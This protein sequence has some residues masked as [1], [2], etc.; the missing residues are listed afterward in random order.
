MVVRSGKDVS[1]RLVHDAPCGCTLLRHRV[2]KNALFHHNIHNRRYD[3]ATSAPL[4]IQGERLVVKGLSGSSSD[5]KGSLRVD[6]ITSV[7]KKTSIIFGAIA[8]IYGGMDLQAAAY[9]SSSD[10][11]MTPF[12]RKQQEKLKRRE[13]LSALREKAEQNAASVSSPGSSPSQSTYKPSVAPSVPSIKDSISKAASQVDQSQDGKEGNGSQSFELPKFT[14][15]KVDMPS[16]SAPK[17]DVPSF[18][19]P[20]VDIPAPKVEIPSKPPAP[21]QT[22]KAPQVVVPESTRP[23]QSSGGDAL[24]EWQQQQKKDMAARKK[25]EAQ[26]ERKNLQKR[27]GSIPLWFTEF[28]LIGTF[29]GFGF[30]SI[31]FQEQIKGMYKKIDNALAGLF[32]K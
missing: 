18:S 25:I 32:M 7:A 21:T 14:A 16:F 1:L 2:L 5:P 8:F 28:L 6:D 27:K 29:V 15:P 24:E 31:A 13:K 17:I 11:S 10:D 12:E 4:R 20:K 3:I 19:A 9:E 23:K 26:T 30:A 22:F